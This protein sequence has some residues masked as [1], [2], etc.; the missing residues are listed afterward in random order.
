MLDRL[1]AP[2]EV[3]LIIIERQRLA[4]IEFQEIGAWRTRFGAP[5]C[6]ISNVNTCHFSTGGQ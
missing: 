1:T 2:D 5:D 6:F 4:I 3:E